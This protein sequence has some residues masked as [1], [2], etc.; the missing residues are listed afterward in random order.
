MKRFRDWTDQKS[1]Q[2]YIGFNDSSGRTVSDRQTKAYGAQKSTTQEGP[3]PSEA[4]FT[5][6]EL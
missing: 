4:S 5:Q 1:G 3:T 2:K 6:T